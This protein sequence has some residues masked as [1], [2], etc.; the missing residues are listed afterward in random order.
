MSNFA[1]L[2]KVLNPCTQLC[3]EHH[4]SYLQ[5]NSSQNLTDVKAIVGEQK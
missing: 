4:H 5:M 1:N 2:Q 3:V